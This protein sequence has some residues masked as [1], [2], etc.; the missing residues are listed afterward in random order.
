MMV[1]FRDMIRKPASTTRNHGDSIWM[2]KAFPSATRPLKDPR[3]VFQLLKK[4]YSRYSLDKVSQITGMS[5]DQLKEIYET[6]TATGAKNKT[7]TMLYAMG[8][9]QHT[10]GVQNIRAMAMIQLLLGNVGMAGGGINA[11]RGE[12]NVQGSTDH[13]LLVHILPGYLKT[14][15]A[16]LATLKDYDVKFTPTTKDPMSANWWGNYPKY[17]ASLLK[18]MYPE[19]EPAESYTWLPKLD[20]GKN[21]TWLK[22]FDNMYKGNFQGFFA[23]GQNPAAGG[24][25]SNKT[26]EALSKLDWMV[27]VNIFENETGSF[28][29]GPG[30]DS[31]KD[32][33]RGFLSSLCGFH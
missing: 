12:S 5:E 21:Y 11:L 20:D 23:W 33:D 4:H 22:L 24:A 26:R 1:C 14:P 18:A 17:S 19:V 8:Q 13:C 10:V 16:S 28:W 2:T 7:G 25:N 15:P 27:N 9:T 6:Y 30:M 32:Q 29:K 3:C 31:P